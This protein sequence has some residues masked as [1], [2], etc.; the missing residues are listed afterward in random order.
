MIGPVLRILLIGLHGAA[1]AAEQPLP[2]AEMESVLDSGQVVAVPGRN[3]FAPASAN[4]LVVDA[5]KPLPAITSAPNARFLRLNGFTRWNEGLRKLVDGMPRLA[6]LVVIGEAAELTDDWKF[7]CALPELRY[8]RLELAHLDTLPPWFRDLKQL[9]GLDLSRNR[10]RGIP[11]AVLALT[12]LEELDLSE[13]AID[14]IDDSLA[15]LTALRRLNL[16]HNAIRV[17]ARS[18]APPPS[19]VLLELEHNK[20]EA[21]PVALITGSKLE[22]LKLEYNYFSEVPESWLTTTGVKR[23]SLSNFSGNSDVIVKQRP[24][25]RLTL[26]GK[27]D[28][29]RPDSPRE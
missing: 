24:D 12:A 15:A 18:V 25:I 26:F 4:A 23:L 29:L 20:L 5:G 16:A 13:N 27:E 3:N 11:P 21:A 9:R 22:Q 7:L 14:R 17:V 10:L 1:I 19:L 6:Y 28:V 8:L 2:S